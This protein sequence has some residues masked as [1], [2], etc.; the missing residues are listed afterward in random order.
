MVCCT[1]APLVRA[2]PGCTFPGCC[3]GDPLPWAPCA[4][5][6]QSLTRVQPQPRAWALYAYLWGADPLPCT[7][8]ESSDP[9]LSLPS[10][11]ISDAPPNPTSSPCISNTPSPELPLGGRSG[12]TVSL[13][14]S[15]T[16][17]LALGWGEALQAGSLAETLAKKQG[18]V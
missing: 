7:P 16:G 17:R 3:V 12:V 14:S 9:V 4:L 8:P 13:L 15:I 18:R 11:G 2:L 6:L 1:H 5:S 10:P